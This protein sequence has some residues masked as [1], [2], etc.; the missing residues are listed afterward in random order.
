[1][2]NILTIIGKVKKNSGR[3]KLLGFPTANLD[4]DEATPEGIYLGYTNFDE[5]RLPSLIFVGRAVTFGET[6]KRAESYILDFDGD[7]YGKE[8]RLELVEKI[9]DGRKFAAEQE[10]VMQIKGDEKIARVYFNL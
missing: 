2:K 6:K 4:V 9:R 3:G 10:M 1:M 7:L 8:I 5:K